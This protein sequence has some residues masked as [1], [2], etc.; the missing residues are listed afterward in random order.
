MGLSWSAGLD[1]DFFRRLRRP[2]AAE[3][4]RHLGSALALDPTFGAAIGG[5]KFAGSPRGPLQQ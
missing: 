1:A 3:E 4:P 2:K 5:A